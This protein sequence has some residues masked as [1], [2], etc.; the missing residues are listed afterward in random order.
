MAT[1]SPEAGCNEKEPTLIADGALQD[2]DGAEYRVGEIGLFVARGRDQAGDVGGVTGVGLYEAGFDGST[3]Y[4]IVHEGNSLHASPVSASLAF[5]LLDNLPTGTSAVVGSH[6]ANRHYVATGVGNRRIEYVSAAAGLTSYTIGMSVSTYSIG[7]SV[8]QGVS[9]MSATTGLVYWVTEYDSTRGIESLTGASVSTGEFSLK[10]GVV[11]TVTGSP[12]NALADQIRW[13]RS[14]D[15]GGFPDGGLVATTAIGTTSIT[16]T[17]TQTGSL[18]VPLYGLISIGGLD[19]E[20]DEAPGVMSTIFGPFQDSLLGVAVAEPRV[21]RFTPAGYP[22]SWPSAYGIPLET[23]RQDNIVIGVVMPGRIGVF[24]NDSVH[25]VYRLPRDSDSIFAAGEMMEVVTGARGCVSR[26]GAA[27]FTPPR[28]PALAAWVARDGIWVSTLADSPSPATDAIDWEGRV[29]VANL[30]TCRLLDD[31]TNRRLIF[32]YRRATDTTYN[33]GIWYLD[34]QRFNE[35]GIRVTFADHGPLVDAQTVAWVDGQRRALSLDSRSG[36]GQVYVESTQ[37]VDDSQLLSSSG[38]V[39]FRMRTKEFMPG[40]PRGVV[41]LGKATWMHDAGPAVID[42]RFYFNRRDDNPET[43]VMPNPTE[44]NGD[45]VVLGRDVN[46]FSLEIQSV[47][48]QSYGVHWIDVE[49][50]DLSSAGA[51]KGA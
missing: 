37:D 3:A 20:R 8:T 25:V 38:T 39:R 12:A 9:T 14:V 16:D 36:N 26:R 31:S 21:L 10:D 35:L 49:G 23:S 19:T 46:S 40:G 43:K 51:M 5:S 15:G 6:Y 44:R 13:Y 48:T 24:C 47:G 4:V 7:V 32:L 33:T 1:F 41:S 18:T 2:T 28:S 34:Y 50:L 30:A 45:T 17:L 42:H 11:A 22:D 27:V 29:S